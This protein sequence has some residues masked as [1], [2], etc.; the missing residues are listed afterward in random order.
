MAQRTNLKAKITKVLEERVSEII[1]PRYSFYLQIVPT[2]MKTHL[3]V[4]IISDHFRKIRNRFK[5]DDA[6]WDVLR[7]HLSPDERMKIGMISCWTE[8]ESLDFPFLDHSQW[9]NDGQPEQRKHRR[10]PCSSNSSSAK[11]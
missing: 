11:A 1:P 10:Q 7:E 5:R 9:A 6:V 3:H 8:E 4:C 2:E